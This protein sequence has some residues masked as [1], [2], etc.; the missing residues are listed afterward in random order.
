MAPC[1][2]LVKGE[3][4]IK[5]HVAKLQSW[6]PSG[7]ASSIRTYGRTT[8]V[9]HFLPTLKLVDHVYSA[10]RHVPVEHTHTPSPWCYTACHIWKFLE[11]KPCMLCMDKCYNVKGIEIL[12]WRNAP[13]AS[14]RSF[15]IYGRETFQLRWKV[16]QC[17][18]SFSNLNRNL[19]IKI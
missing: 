5:T 16:L 9:L 10:D 19:E 1:Q 2:Q 14:T 7:D 3:A 6:P 17:D 12:I 18:F 15:M 13:F 11:K 8:W 4:G